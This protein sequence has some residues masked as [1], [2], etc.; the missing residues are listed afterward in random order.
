MPT[1]R[2][3]L[4]QLRA[5]ASQGQATS[6]RAELERLRAM[7]QQPIQEVKQPTIDDI[8]TPS[9]ANILGTIAEKAKGVGEFLGFDKAT[10]PLARAAARL[11]TPKEE[12]GI[13]A[14]PEDI[15]KAIPEPSAAELTGAG[16]QIGTL[17][18]PFRQLQM[19]L[20]KGFGGLAPKA[21]AQALGMVGAGAS[22]G[23]AFETGEKLQAG[24]S[25]GEVLTPGVATAVGAAIPLVPMAAKQISK[26]KPQQ[27]AERL[28]ESTVRPSTTLRPE[29]RKR[30]I[31][32]ALDESI[33]PTKAGLEKT[34]GLIT[35]YTNKVDDLIE[36]GMKR[37]GAKATI[38]TDDVLTRLDDVK[39]YF[40]DDLLGENPIGDIDKIAQKLK[41]K[42]PETM[43]V[44]DAQ[45]VKRT[46]QK[47][48]KDAFGEHS[49]AKKEAAKQIS[50]GIREELENVFP[51]IAELNQKSRGLIELD[52]ELERAVGRL[53]NRNLFGLTTKIFTA[54]GVS[55][56]A[57][58]AGLILALSESVLG[59]PRV[60]ART[61]IALSKVGKAKV[62]E[63]LKGAFPKVRFPGDV[64]A[65]DIIKGV[66]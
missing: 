66:K 59:N 9:D 1:P 50:R 62:N 53:S 26:M 38:K 28:F 7:D 51:E 23:Y 55:K 17:F 43:N 10:D 13:H 49:T 46:L 33:V 19:A 8:Q 65:E 31:K 25:M 64:I 11:V 63:R 12:F 45:R 48:L 60:K 32:T 29:A 35:K 5:M 52:K 6:P 40:D 27:F 56:E 54:A 15:E 58:G 36:E 4:E 44:R 39:A 16:L 41:D 47:E 21:V 42:F 22:G 2:Q 37:G 24:K 30:I 61:A 3:E 20:A 14:T 34:K 57:P 18:I